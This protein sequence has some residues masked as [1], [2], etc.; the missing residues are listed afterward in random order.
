MPLKKIS[1]RQE[2]L[3]RKPWII[4]Q[5]LVDICK[6]RSMFK[7]FYRKIIPKKNF[8]DS[9]L[10]QLGKTIAFAKK[11]YFA[12]VLDKNIHNVVI[13]YTLK[14]WKNYSG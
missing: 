3:K 7:Y 11:S 12:K 4:K 8:E 10:E 1:R 14:F 5:T 2:T 6:R 9:N 13:T